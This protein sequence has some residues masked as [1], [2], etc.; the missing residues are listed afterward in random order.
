[1]SELRQLLDRIRAHPDCVV[2]PA[3]GLPQP[4]APHQLPNDV[5]EFYTLCGGVEFFVGSEVLFPFRIVAPDEVVRAN[6]KFFGEL[7]A[8]DITAQWYLIAE[9]FNGDCLSID[10]APERLGRCYDSNHEVHGM[11][12]SCAVVARSFTE[13]LTFL[14]EAPGD[15]VF[16]RSDRFTPLGDAYDALQ[17]A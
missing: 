11:V 7:Y 3:T 17:R 6:L 8:D 9:D 16:W 4:V 14:W 12:G 10:L 1:M 5:N 2:L 13:L 15:E